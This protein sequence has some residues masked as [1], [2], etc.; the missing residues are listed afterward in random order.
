MLTGCFLP[1]AAGKPKRQGELAY[2]QCVGTSLV[3]L[4][5]QWV[6]QQAGRADDDGDLVSIQPQRKVIDGQ[7]CI[8]LDHAENREDPYRGMV[9]GHHVHV[10]DRQSA[11][12]RTLLRAIPVES[13]TG[14]TLGERES[15]TTVLWGDQ[16]DL[17]IREVRS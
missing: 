15:K 6:T 7:E 16:H 3:G 17:L 14:E 1:Q 5:G 4:T 9:D 2:P 8:A 13:N 12:Q 10:A 11:A